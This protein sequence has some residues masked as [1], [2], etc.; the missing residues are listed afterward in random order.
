MGTGISDVDAVEEKAVLVDEGLLSAISTAPLSADTGGGTGMGVKDKESLRVFT[1]G[2]CSAFK[3]PA[4]MNASFNS[5]SLK[6]D[7]VSPKG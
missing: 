6:I 1:A 2:V 5:V 7:I 3:I 4:N